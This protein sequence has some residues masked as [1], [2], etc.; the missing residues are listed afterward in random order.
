M[1]TADGTTALV[2]YY[3]DRWQAESGRQVDREAFAWLYDLAAVQRCLKA[4]GTF[5]AM[6]VVHNRPHYLPYIP[7]TLACLRP[8]MQRYERL[9]PLND[10]L[11]RFTPL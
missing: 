3:L 7:P 8:L 9:R 1:L 5:A 10:L 2:A 4:T 6:H 11:Q